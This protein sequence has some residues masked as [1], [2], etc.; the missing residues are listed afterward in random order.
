MKMKQE[1]NS[2]NTFKKLRTNR[3]YLYSKNWSVGSS[4]KEFGLMERKKCVNKLRQETA[5][6][7]NKNKRSKTG[8][9]QRKHSKSDT[10]HSTL[11]GHMLRRL[12]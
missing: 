8:S 10:A 4:A 11:L 6:L 2:K 3:K 1:R 12:S 9:E 5:K 7:K